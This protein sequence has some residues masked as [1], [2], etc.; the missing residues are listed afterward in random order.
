[1]LGA[2][3]SQNGSR[4]TRDQGQT[5][6]LAVSPRDELLVLDWARMKVLRY[7]IDYDALRKEIRIF[8]IPFAQL[9]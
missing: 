5:F 9:K 1:M 7:H 2:L 8:K 6:C 4:L 3:A